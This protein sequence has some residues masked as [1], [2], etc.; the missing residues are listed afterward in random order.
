MQHRGIAA[1][2]EAAG[3]AGQA[4]V[5][6]DH[7]AAAVRA[8]THSRIIFL[9]LD[10]S[11]ITDD[12]ADGIRAGKHLMPVAPGRAWAADPGYLFEDRRQADTGTQGQGY[13]TTGGLNLGG[14][15][16]A[17][18]AHLGKDFANPPVVAVDRHI[19]FS[20]AGGNSF[21]DP[22]GSRRSGSGIDLGLSCGFV[23]V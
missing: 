22:F 4:S 17:G 19:Q 3:M 21:G 1:T 11:E 20:T 8:G 23:E 12:L 15:T 6:M 2:G 9:N 16:A 14:G 18:L 7:L 10:L 5:F 13:H